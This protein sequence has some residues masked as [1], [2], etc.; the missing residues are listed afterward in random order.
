MS[1]EAILA[2]HHGT[3]TAMVLWLRL[4]AAG[5]PGAWW[6]LGVA[7]GMMVATRALLYCHLVICHGARPW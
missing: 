2:L 1:T 4:R 3:R 7:F 5:V 6:L